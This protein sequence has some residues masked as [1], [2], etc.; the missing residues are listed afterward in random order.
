M[1]SGPKN[2]LTDVPGI[3]VGH[4][5]ILYNNFKTGVTAILPHQDN[6]FLKKLPAAVHVINGF[7]K[8]SG[9][10]QVNELGVLESPLV[11]TNTFGVGTAAN[12]LVKRALAENPEIGETTG[13]FNPLVFECNDGRINDIRGLAVTEADVTAALS[14]TIEKFALGAVGA[15]TG[16]SCY[17]LKGGIGSASRIIELQDQ[18]FTLGCLVL[19]NFGQL[20]N[21]VVKNYPIGLDLA[22]FFTSSDAG[23]KGSVIVV[24]ATDLPLSDRQLARIS[25]R[26]SVG[27]TRSG[28]FIGNG[29]GEIVCS[30]STAQPIAH[31]EQA[32]VHQRDC[33]NENYLDQVFEAVAEVVD[34]AVLRSL[35]FSET[36]L[37]RQQRPV[38]NLL[39]AIDKLQEQH[40]SAA[41]DELLNKLNV[42]K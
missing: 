18:S 9:L 19:T 24:L 35:I 34:E 3:T 17:G 7:G 20:K 13:T 23:E 14:Q 21:L 12:A 26:A 30:F 22:E 6:L 39:A 40:F 27:I 2:L 25:R 4:Q 15:G 16:M 42:L 38:W 36:T 1:K 10:T 37:D 31:F 33:F 28:S 11:L 29:S 5:T 41:R 32:V 8:S